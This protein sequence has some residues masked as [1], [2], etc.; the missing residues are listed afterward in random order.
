MTPGFKRRRAQRQIAL[1]KRAEFDARQRQLEMQIA[2][3]AA[4]AGRDDAIRKLALTIADGQRLAECSTGELAPPFRVCP[5]YP[6][7]CR[8]FPAECRGAGHGLAE[9]RRIA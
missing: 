9:F 3:D 2:V 7:R 1:V 8:E 4:C 5:D 6:R